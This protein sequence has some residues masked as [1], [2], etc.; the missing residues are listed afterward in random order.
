MALDIELL[1][2]HTALR[3]P[4]QT[5]ETAIRDGE[6]DAQGTG[7]NVYIV[8]LIDAQLTTMDLNLSLQ[9]E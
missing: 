3:H 1:T 9:H 4:L 2:W 8:Q 5:T 6:V 7:N